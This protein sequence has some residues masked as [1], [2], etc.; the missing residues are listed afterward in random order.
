MIPARVEWTLLR[1]LLGDCQPAVAE[2]ERRGLLL[3]DA[4]GVW[5]RHELGRRAVER[6]LPTTERI[7]HH[8]GVLAAAEGVEPVVDPRG[9]R[10][11]P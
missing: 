3:A 5:F 7:G 11:T 4:R 2:A 9:W 6:A 10:T 1:A 8:R